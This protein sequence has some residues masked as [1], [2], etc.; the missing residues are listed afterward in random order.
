MQGNATTFPRPD[1]LYST[2]TANQLIIISVLLNMKRI[3]FICYLQE[4]AN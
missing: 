4:E 3:L 2:L 1:K